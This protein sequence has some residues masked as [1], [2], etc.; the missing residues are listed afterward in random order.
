MRKY[1]NTPLRPLTLQYPTQIVCHRGI[2]GVKRWS[3]INLGNI[4]IECAGTR[5]EKSIELSGHHCISVCSMVRQYGGLGQECH[6]LV[7][8]KTYQIT[9]RGG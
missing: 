2:P 8:E 5:A 4:G 1:K 9:D 6:A 3:K 7:F